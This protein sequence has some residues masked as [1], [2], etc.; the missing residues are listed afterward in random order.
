[1]D[2]WTHKIKIKK[3]SYSVSFSPCCGGNIL[4]ESIQS[5]LWYEDTLG[6]AHGELFASRLLW[7]EIL[8]FE[9]ETRFMLG[10]FK[11]QL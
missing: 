10:Q 6:K 9:D 5:L 2:I 3:L 11:Q 4:L 8:A 7:V 1:M